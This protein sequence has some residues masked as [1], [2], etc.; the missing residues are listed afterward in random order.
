MVIV[1]EAPKVTLDPYLKDAIQTL[2]EEEAQVIIHLHLHFP[3]VSKIRIWKSTFLKPH[4]NRKKIKLV[5][6]I[7]VSFYPIWTRCK[8]GETV[9]T[10]IFK[11]LPKDCTVFDMIEE[12][13]ELGGFY[14]PNIQ[15]NNSGVYHLQINF[16]S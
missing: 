5:H 2:M 10:L 11:G 3:Y 4:N 6:A 13:P 15:R 12:I 9:C 7:N 16:N 1:E 8:I 14:I